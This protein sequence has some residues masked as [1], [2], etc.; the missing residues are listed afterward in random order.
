M[1]DFLNY[2]RE[3][4]FSYIS[5]N[6][7]KHI[8]KQV[9]SH[10]QNQSLAF[11]LSRETGKI[12]RIVGK[13]STSFA[14]VLRYQFFSL[15]PTFTEIIFIVAAIGVLYGQK[16]FWIVF[17]CVTV[18]M[19]VTIVVTEWRAKFFKRMS[20]ADAAY[21]QKATDSLLN[22]ETVKYFNAEDHEQNRFAKSLAVYKE[23]NV[24]V[25]KTL[26][27]LNMSQSL[28]IVASLIST[29]I[30]AYMSIKLGELTISDFVV[31]NQYI[32]QVYTPLGFL[33]TYWRFIRQAWS[34]IE[35]V[36]DI[37]TVNETIKEI[38]NPIKADIHS[39]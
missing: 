34:D 29:L 21:T 22:F 1:S 30:L 35:L 39:G 32:L 37:L 31:F 4:P 33:G 17:G 24:I 3:I 8:A 10:I 28:V 6:A 25:A 18:Y 16:F 19:V 2:I 36:L 15:L 5:A 26:V 23:E 11:H 9:Y 7:E 27:T 13:G 38:D 14:Q 12:V 20:K